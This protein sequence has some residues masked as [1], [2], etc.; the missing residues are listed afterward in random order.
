MADTIFLAIWLV[1]IVFS[2]HMKFVSPIVRYNKELKEICLNVIE[3]NEEL[4]KQI[5]H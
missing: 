3:A 1:V 4:R 2:Y 5:N